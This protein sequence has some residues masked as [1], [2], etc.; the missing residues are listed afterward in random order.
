MCNDDWIAFDRVA[1]RPAQA[2]AS[3]HIVFPNSNSVGAASVNY[4]GIT[5]AG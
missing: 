3:Q 2:S 5:Q 4:H 1:A